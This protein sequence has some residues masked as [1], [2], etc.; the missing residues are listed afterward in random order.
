[1]SAARAAA[2]APC[3]LDELRER[4][5]VDELHREIDQPVR[6]LAEVVD[7]GDVR[8]LDPA[9]VRRFAIEAADRVRRRA[10]SPGCITLI[11]LL[12]PHLH[13]LGEIHLAHAA[14]ADAANHVVAI[15]EDGA[16]EIAPRWRTQ[17]WTRR[18]DRSAGPCRRCCRIAGRF[19]GERGWTT[20]RGVWGIGC[21]A[22]FGRL[23]YKI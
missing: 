1:M 16:D 17:A 2:S 8:V 5:A 4:L 9:R 11:A 19:S 18:A 6:R 22:G 3:A 7:R 10:P 20:K 21:G 12:P 13:V 14:F 23:Q 15:G